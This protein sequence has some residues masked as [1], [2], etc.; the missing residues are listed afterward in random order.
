MTHPDEI[1]AMQAAD[2]MSAD[3]TYLWDLA[4]QNA[5]QAGLRYAI[6]RREGGTFCAAFRHWVDMAACLQLYPAE[7]TFVDLVA[8]QEEAARLKA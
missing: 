6:M 5:I 2:A 7:F 3:A 8:N 1:Q 4:C